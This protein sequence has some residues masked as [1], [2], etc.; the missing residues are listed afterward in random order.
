[1]ATK[2]KRPYAIC[3]LSDDGQEWQTLARFK[4]YDNADDRLDSYCDR[5]PYAYITIMKNGEE[6]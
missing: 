3:R 1:M 5:F 6:V 4:S 2:S